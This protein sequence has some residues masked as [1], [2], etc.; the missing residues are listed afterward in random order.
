MR[1]NQQAFTLIEIAIAVFIM[2]L[3]MAIAVPSLSG[4]LA[5]RRLQ[6]SLDQFNSLVRAAQ[7]RAV[8]DRR[9]Y[10]I[11]WGKD[12]I[13]LR[14]ESVPKSEDPK[15]TSVLRLQRGD[16]FLLKLTAALTKDPPA[17]WIFWPTGTCEPATVT[18][19]G[20]DGTWT[21]DYGAL[22]ARP[23]ITRYAAK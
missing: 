6:R 15:P 13:I 11:A 19:K 12:Q 23:E 17:Q 18:Y 20:V 7:E 14:S 1:K 3:L 8:T 2:L 5:N 22:T 9:P 10:L 21:A 16:A 4:V